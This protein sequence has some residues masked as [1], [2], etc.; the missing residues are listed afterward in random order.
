MYTTCLYCHGNLG[1]NEAVETFPVG[2]RLAFDPALGRLWVV[3]GKCG[4]WNLS[5]LDERWEAIE[6]CERLFRGT[7]LR[8][9]TG[10]IGLGRVKEG[11][12]LVRIGEPERPELAAWR[13]GSTI[14]RRRRKTL[15]TTGVIVAVGLPLFASG[16]YSALAALIPGGGAAL[17]LVNVANTIYQRR[18]VMVRTVSETGEPVLIRA[19]QVGTARINAGRDSEESWGLEIEQGKRRPVQIT[20][21]EAV[22]V[23]GRVMALVNQTGGSPKIVSRAVDR[24]DQAGGG[25]GLLTYLGANAHFAYTGVRLVKLLPAEERIALEMATHEESERRA[26]EGEL[27]EL[28]LAW[29]EAEEIAAIADSLL[30]P[31]A[32]DAF[33]S[34]YRQGRGEVPGEAD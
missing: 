28:R 21:S 14:V 25:T 10:E 27:A 33:L 24:L 6:S 15:I 9:S 8:V 7:R 19:S 13:Y 12:E 5:A 18:R 26:L 32:V 16:A 23:L 4:R 30:L 2:R 1:A 17:H 22:R 29:Q 11:L 3:C 20:G 31:P 34:R